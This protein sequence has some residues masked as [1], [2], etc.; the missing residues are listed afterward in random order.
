LG[1]FRLIRKPADDLTHDLRKA[2]AVLG[3]ERVY[4]IQAQRIKLVQVVLFLESIQFVDGEK[5]R[6]IGFTKLLDGLSINRVKPALAIKQK[7]NHV[8]FR[9]GIAALFLNPLFETAFGFAI[10]TSGID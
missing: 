2:N 10:Q 3:R 1:I 9:D 4:P 5:Y 6:L 7:E 8:S